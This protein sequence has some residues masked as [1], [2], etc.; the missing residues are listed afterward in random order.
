LQYTKTGPKRRRRTRRD[1]N[2]KARKGLGCTNR[3]VRM[4]WFRGAGIHRYSGDIG[5]DPTA[6]KIARQAP[7]MPLEY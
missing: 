4:D 5:S 6:N 7:A 1:G 2:E 3:S